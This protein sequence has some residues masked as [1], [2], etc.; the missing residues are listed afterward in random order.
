M[1]ALTDLIRSRNN[2]LSQNILFLILTIK[3]H[4]GITQKDKEI[5]SQ[6][7]NGLAFCNLQELLEKDYYPLNTL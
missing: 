6:N 3:F 7:D 1:T 4:E 2:S 5:S